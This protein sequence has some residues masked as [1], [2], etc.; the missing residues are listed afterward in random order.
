MVRQL[1][2]RG[3]KFVQ[4]YGSIRPPRYKRGWQALRSVWAETPETPVPAFK[5]YRF[6]KGAWP[7]LILQ[8][9]MRA[10]RDNEAEKPASTGRCGSHLTGMIE[11]PRSLCR[12][13]HKQSR[14]RCGGQ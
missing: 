2:R 7:E 12:H 4:C 10:A 6:K 9:V 11:H 13:R 5:V 8:A 3:S 14:N 1:R